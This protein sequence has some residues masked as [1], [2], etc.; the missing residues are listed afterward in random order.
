MSGIGCAVVDVAATGNALIDGVLY[1]VG[2]SGPIT[3]AFPDNPA[4]YSY[5]KEAQASFA[6]A[7]VGQRAATLFALEQSAGTSADDGFSVEG[8][9]NAELSA[10]DAETANLRVAQSDVPRTS[11]TYMTPEH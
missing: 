5:Q 8:F 3:Y 1:G 6:A 9:T 7:T 4:D 10:G 2:W 11:Y